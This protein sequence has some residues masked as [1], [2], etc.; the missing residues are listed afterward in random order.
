[1]TLFSPAGES[2]SDV[3]PM[4]VTFVA[5]PVRAKP[6]AYS[7]HKAASLATHMDPLTEPGTVYRN[8]Q[9][10]YGRLAMANPE[11]LGKA[12]YRMVSD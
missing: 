12:G 9:A 8:D 4:N 7:P 11:G 2:P 3:A 5:R 6:R 1:M 10:L